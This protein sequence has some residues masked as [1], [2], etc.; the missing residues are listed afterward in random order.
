MSQSKFV[1]GLIQ[2]QNTLKH[3]SKNKGGTMKAS[4]KTVYDKVFIFCQKVYFL[5]KNYGATQK[6]VTSHKSVHWL[7]SL[8]SV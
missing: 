4:R 2:A 1:F 5:P 8:Y 6:N 3:I 7:Q